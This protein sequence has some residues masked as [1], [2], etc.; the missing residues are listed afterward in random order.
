MW[1]FQ[2]HKV[3]YGK[4]MSN[5]RWTECHFSSTLQRFFSEV[6]ILGQLSS[7]PKVT[8]G[9]YRTDSR[10]VVQ[11]TNREEYVLFKFLHF[12]SN[13]IQFVN[14]FYHVND[15]SIQFSICLSSQV[16]N[17]NNDQMIKVLWSPLRMHQGTFSEPSDLEG[18]SLHRVNIREAQKHYISWE[19]RLF[20][21]KNNS[22]KD[23]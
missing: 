12:C 15:I 7:S 5:W 17:S 18:S 13:F 10:D 23:N 20:S 21:F 8:K 9:V 14:Y 4:H 6:S 2:S 16:K 3:K 1:I 22:L 19:R 11:W